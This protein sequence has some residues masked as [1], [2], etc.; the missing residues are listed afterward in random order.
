MQK[1]TISATLLI[2]VLV[3]FAVLYAIFVAGDHL[4]FTFAAADVWHSERQ[5]AVD[6][7]ISWVQRGLYLVLWFMPVLFTILA[8]AYALRLLLLMRKGALFDDQIPHYLRCVGVGTSGSGIT[9]IIANVC[10]DKVLSWTNPLGPMPLDW[11]F[12]SEPAGIVLCGG[13]FY[14]IGWIMA[15]ARKVHEEVES[16]V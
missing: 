10:D 9:D 16:F 14:L 3:V 7:P 1:V 15:E 8:V 13:G 2:P 6:A 4:G 11:Y 12:D 5:V